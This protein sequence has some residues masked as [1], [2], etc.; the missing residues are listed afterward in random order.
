[1]VHYE[2]VA[3]WEAYATG[4]YHTSTI[5]KQVVLTGRPLATG[6]CEIDF[7]TSPPVFTKPKDPESLE[8][9][10]LRLAA[11]YEWVVVQTASTGQFTALLNHSSVLRTWDAVAQSLRDLTSADDQLT[12][13]LIQFI[14]QQLRDPANFMRSLR[15]DYLYN[16]LVP[17]FYAQPL[18]GPT[19]PVRTREF[20]QFF[21]KLPLVFFEQ[22]EVLPAEGD[23]MVTLVLRGNLDSQKTDVPTIHKL[24]AAAVG[25]AND[26]SVAPHFYYEA[27]HVLDSRTGLP[28]RVELTVYGRLAAVYNKQYTLTISRL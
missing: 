16:T 24:M 27:C 3:C 11:L 8:T 13:T 26:L 23:E 5:T 14:S 25:A 2:A 17:D 15:H 7:R 22:I 10:V 9:M 1:M 12:P 28:Q 21:D 20:S 6:G 19:S 18:G 4:D